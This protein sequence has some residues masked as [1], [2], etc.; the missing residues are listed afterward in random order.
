MYGLYFFLEETCKRTK[1]LGF[2]FTFLLA[3]AKVLDAIL[4]LSNSKTVLFLK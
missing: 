2:F 3:K 1:K 4:F